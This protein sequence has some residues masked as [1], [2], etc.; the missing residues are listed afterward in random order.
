MQL[1]GGRFARGH[2]AEIVPISGGKGG[3]GKTL[4]ASNVAI[5]LA[6][7]GHSTVVVDLD[8][9]A[10][11]LF[12]FLG[13][14][15]RYPGIGDFLKAR[16]GKLEDLLVQTDVPNL[17]YLPGDGRTPFMANIGFAQKQKL[18]TA[19]YSLPFEYVLLDLGSGST[20]NTLDFFAMGKTGLMVTTPDYPAVVNM[21]TFLKNHLFR[22]IERSVSPNHSVK[23]IL[24]E[25]YCQPIE[26][27]VSSVSSLQAQIR[28]EDPAAAETVARICNEF[29]PRIVFN[30][31]TSPKDLEFT[32]QIDE[33]LRNVLYLEA[34]YFGFIFMDAQVRSS[35]RERQPLV[36]SHPESPAAQEMI[37]IADRILRFWST[38]VPNSSD[39][40][41]NHARKTFDEHFQGH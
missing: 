34:D 1:K 8:L 7:A 36:L 11:N 14:T 22:S 4:V 38:P 10:S 21:L 26:E 33:G 32:D 20:F 27:Q 39:L 35:V 5:G 16:R 19:L 18:L 29:R 37:K 2:R 6:Q 31:G 9:G 15:N 24:Q 28:E 17:Y 3:V 30:M 13:L 40:I 41:L 23:G 25:L 12:A